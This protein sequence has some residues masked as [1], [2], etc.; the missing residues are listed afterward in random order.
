MRSIVIPLL[1]CISILSLEGCFTAP[2]Y[3]IV[4][5]ISFEDLT[6]EKE[7]IFGTLVL[8][9][10][11]TDGD[12]DLGLDDSFRTDTAYTLQYYLVNPNQD[13]SKI[14]L[15]LSPFI[16]DNEQKKYPNLILITE[17]Y[18]RKNP[19]LKLPDGSTFPMLLNCAN[20]KEKKSM[21]MGTWQQRK[22]EGT[23]KVK[24]T[25]FTFYNES[26]YNIFVDILIDDGT[27]NFIP[28]NP[29]SI[30][31]FPDCAPSDFN[32]FFPVLSSDPGKKAPLDGDLTYRMKSTK[33][34]EIFGTKR[35]K[36]RI[37]IMDRSYHKSNIIET[38]PT[39]LAEIRTI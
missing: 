8:K 13:L 21:K 29:N 17:G 1:V 30:S 19:N 4:P 5:K 22:I 12:G 31:S 33:T 32:G 2:T 34:E 15:K 7:G 26:Y 6:Y 28:F 35:F 37:Q 9:L 25:V 24:D 27:N 20:W 23:D 16:S 38:E 39:T 14:D 36:L 3:P 11:F 18:T 10:K